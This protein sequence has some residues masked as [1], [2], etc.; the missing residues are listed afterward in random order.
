MPIYTY[1]V[2]YLITITVG[3]LNFHKFS[4][5]KQLNMFIYFLVYSLISEIIGS[6]LGRVLIVK[7]NIV[8]NTWNIVNLLFFSYFFLTRIADK[9]KRI[10]IYTLISTFISITLINVIFFSNYIDDLLL[11]NLM[12]AKLL[13]VFIII[14]YF[15]ELLASDT[16]LNI[17]NSLFFWISL[18]IFLYNLAFIPAFALFKYTSVYGMFKY[19]TLG[20]NI[21]MHLCFITGFIISIK[22]YNY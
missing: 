17:K 8:Y 10:I 15:T 21:I 7:N 4:H 16:V 12:L 11:N 13:L 6:Y 14:I 18:G 20:L 9:N 5:N 19:I 2:I 3:L 22:K 1:P